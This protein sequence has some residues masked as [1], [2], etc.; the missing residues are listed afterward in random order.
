MI[1]FCDKEVQCFL[2]GELDRGELMQYFL[3]GHMDEVVYVIREDARYV[4]CITCY[5]L[6]G[7]D[8]IEQG[9]L[10]GCVLFDEHIWENAR[11]FFVCHESGFGEPALLPVVN[12]QGQ[13]ICFAYE[14]IHANREIRMLRELSELPDVLHFSDIYP[15]IDCVKIE[16]FNELAYFFVKYLKEH[17]IPVQVSGDMWHDIYE[18]GDASPCLDYACMTVYAEGVGRKSS[19]WTENLLR[20]ACVEFECIDKIYEANVRVGN[21]KNSQG[22]WDGIKSFLRGKNVAII[23]TDLAAQDTYD[24]LLMHGIEPYCF[25]DDRLE[26]QERRLFGKRICGRLAL[27]KDYGGDIVFIDGQHKN[28]AWGNRISD[29]YDYIGYRRNESYFMLRDYMD[30]PCCGLKH[31]LANAQIALAGDYLPCERVRE[32]LCEKVPAFRTSPV[33][34]NVLPEETE[35]LPDMPIIDIKDIHEGMILLIVLPEFAD[36]S[37]LKFSL[38]KKKRMISCIKERGVKNFTDYFSYTSS[39][40]NMAKELDTKCVRKCFMP[41]MNMIGSI[42]AHNGNIFF[43]GLL[44]NHPSIMLTDYDAFSKNIFWVSVCLANREAKDILTLLYRVFP[45]EC[46]E[47]VLENPEAFHK[48]AAQL[49][50]E[51]EKYTSQE[52]FVIFQIAYM[53]MYGKDI[54]DVSDK[55]IY[56][57]PHCVDTAVVED[58]SQ[59]LGAAG[60]R[61]SIVNVVRDICVTNGSIMRDYVHGGGGR[62]IGLVAIHAFNL[63]KK[64]YTSCR[65]YVV[66]FEDI[67]C[68]PREI[69]QEL[70]SEWEIPWSETLLGV[71][72]HGKKWG[73]DNGEMMVYDFDLTPVY[74]RYEEYFSEN[75][76]FRIRLIS[77][78]WQKKYGY[79]YV[80]VSDFSQRELQEIFLKGFRFDKFR[81]AGREK[82]RLADKIWEMNVIRDRLWE[83]KM[84]EFQENSNRRLEKGGIEY[85][86]SNYFSSRTGDKAQTFDG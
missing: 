48:K 7:V 84:L 3:E 67:K 59:W 14:D 2:Y 26:E 49:L 47:R 11:N 36:N 43:H 28:S 21:I 10:S 33:Y 73:Y 18:G 56:W 68:R 39:F 61:C 83:N 71:T 65:R 38:D 81:N 60:L 8:N 42:E 41:K 53:Y 22:S 50:K 79:P 16:G 78:P 19:D 35:Y 37:V 80:D 55:M 77:I 1:R 31:A 54:T 63:E 70:C 24:Y 64:D 15:D 74:N 25:M 30:V 86:E 85:S 72:C 44:D 75:D 4:G 29:Y 46:R 12:K 34:V 76:R 6:I 82:E 51:E 66:R 40:T 52:L 23:G 32:Y 5:T 17:D 9:I 27:I 57:E 58:F 62:M 20:S 13:L 69:L 45:P